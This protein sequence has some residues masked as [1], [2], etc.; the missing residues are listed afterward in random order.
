MNN[1]GSK[2]R[3]AAC[4]VE[5]DGSLSNAA[6]HEALIAGV[7]D[8][9]LRSRTRAKLLSKGLPLAVLDSVLPVNTTS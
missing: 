7:D 8:L 6:L 9:D 1:L 3:D 2:S 5:S 4:V